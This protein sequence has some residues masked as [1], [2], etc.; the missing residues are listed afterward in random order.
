MCHLPIVGGA[1]GSRTPVRNNFL[2]SFYM[3]RVF[4]LR[5]ALVEPDLHS[6]SV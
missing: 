3:V 1:E 5:P 2:T 4:Y 6:G